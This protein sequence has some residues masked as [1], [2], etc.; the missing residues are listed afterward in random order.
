MKT[1]LAISLFEKN[2]GLIQLHFFAFGVNLKSLIQELKRLLMSPQFGECNGLVVEIARTNRFLNILK[3]RKDLVKHPQLKQSYRKVVVR[4]LVF[5]VNLNTPIK[6]L[7]RAL[8]IL[9]FVIAD[10][11]QKQRLKIMFAE[12][13][14]TWNCLRIMPQVKQTRSFVEIS[15]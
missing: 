15:W 10:A 1:I 12:M 3:F 7:I 8:V 14:Q 13:Q 5:L 9:S 11:C 2:D 6:T 4:V